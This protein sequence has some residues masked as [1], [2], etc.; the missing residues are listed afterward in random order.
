MS[1]HQ[2]I[3]FDNVPAVP[4]PCGSAK[5]ALGEVADFP[6]TIHLTE[7]AV[8]AQTHYHRQHAETYY[9]I[10]CAE[11]AKMELDGELHPIRPGMLVHI[12][13]GVRHR[14]VGA[15]KILNI[16]LPKF[17]PDDEHFD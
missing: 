9:I 5:R 17:D 16:V 14:A 2:I 6:A 3:D 1:R 10:D 12:P 13:V 11:D 8:D 4:C 15:M 7:I